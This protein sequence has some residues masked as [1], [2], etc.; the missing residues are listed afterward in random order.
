MW[1]VCTLEV[2]VQSLLLPLTLCHQNE[3]K[4]DIIIFTHHF[5]AGVGEREAP[6]VG[7]EAVGIGVFQTSER[8]VRDVRKRVEPSLSL[9]A[10]SPVILQPFPRSLR[11]ESFATAS[12]NFRTDCIL[13]IDSTTAGRGLVLQ[14]RADERKCVDGHLG[15]CARVVRRFFRGSMRSSSIRRRIFFRTGR[16]VC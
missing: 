13:F 12:D 7:N 10:T 15:A 9:S 16:E 2:L 1:C 4:C 3:R 11:N 5:S 8:S 6:S 14:E